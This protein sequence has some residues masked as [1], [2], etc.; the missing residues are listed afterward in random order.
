[1]FVSDFYSIDAFKRYLLSQYSTNDLYQSLV[2]RIPNV[3]A[4][5]HVATHGNYS[6]EERQLTLSLLEQHG[7]ILD[8]ASNSL[9]FTVE[10]QP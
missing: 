1:M 5:V 4:M 7:V 2:K 10:L 8:I 6:P 3:K 9:T